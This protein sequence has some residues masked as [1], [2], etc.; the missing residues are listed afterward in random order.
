[1]NL[2]HGQLRP[3]PA[4]ARR[5]GVFTVLIIALA[6]ALT[7]AGSVG[8]DPFAI[9]D[10]ALQRRED[11]SDEE[12]RDFLQRQMTGP[13]AGRADRLLLIAE[14]MKQ[15]GDDRTEDYF[16]RATA[17]GRD[18]AA[19][20][21]FYADYLRNFR[22][23]MRP[24]FEEA[25]EHYIAAL[26]KLG[27]QSPPAPWSE[28]V[29]ARAL[30]GLTALYQEDGLP[31]A[32]REDTEPRAP[33]LFFSSAARRARSLSDLDEVHDIRDL[34]SEALFSGSAARLHRALTR[35][36]LRGL[37]RR[38]EPTVLRERLRYRVEGT[39]LDLTYENLGIRD[40]QVTDFLRPNDFNRV[41]VNNLSAQLGVTG[42]AAPN[43]DGYFRLAF[44]AA[45]R[46]GLVEL[47]PH[48][49]ERVAAGE[50]ELAF[51]SY[52]GTGRNDFAVTAVAQD[53]RP[54][55]A[56]PP[57]RN[58]TT[59]ATRFNHQ[60]L[61]PLRWLR[62]PFGARF[63]ARGL[64]LFAGLADDRERF[65][66]IRVTRDDLF[67]GTSL[68]GLGLVDLML[69]PAL[70]RQEVSGD[71]SQT[72]M[73]LRLEGTLVF[74]LLDEERNPGIPGSFLGLHPA[75]V[76]LVIPAKRDRALKGLS[77]FENDRVGGGLDM[78]FF[79]L[80]RAELA[81]KKGARFGATT[82][83]LSCHYSR[84]RFQRLDKRV[85][86]LELSFSVGF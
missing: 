24:L 50:T 60:F 6:A 54:Q 18:E 81:P 34:T 59:F 56:N 86:L 80:P 29:R 39:A 47:Q 19:Y 46:E 15:S 16:Q 37:V 41:Q 9:V 31:M 13:E 26:E 23:P 83:F 72:S 4:L 78:K 14:L 71:R 62:N 84:Q 25:E 35:D 27:K 64:K 61:R 2:S 44:G 3:K 79:V 43:L 42:N 40:A 5:I 73:Q 67:V 77:A 82:L 85:N 10:Q 36:E 69:Q 28:E 53:I 63:A 52:S 65:G 11:M 57:R 32:W 21:L 30:R 58:R 74:R 12:L 17:A 45:E 22:G 8:S 49:K 48:V 75:F 55:I 70:F 33:F 20:E 76:H 7:S 66:D 51:S 38:K 1:M 68:N